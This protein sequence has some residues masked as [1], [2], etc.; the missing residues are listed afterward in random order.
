[1]NL[2]PHIADRIRKLVAATSTEG[3]HVNNEAARYG[4]IVLMGTL[5]ATWLVRPDGTFWDVD[6]D[7]GK[8]LQPL[9]EGL[10]VLALVYGVERHAWLSELI[11]SRPADTA[12]CAA[13]GGRGRLGP[14]QSAGL[15][16]KEF[17]YCQTCSGLG[18]T[19]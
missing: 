4:G 19:A 12:D 3:G 15:L 2:P 10:Q 16:A 11:P 13:C 14:L 8:P 1:M 7:T 17:I 9:A 6:E 5:G 18:W